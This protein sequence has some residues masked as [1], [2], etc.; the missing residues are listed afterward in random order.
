[1]DA[2]RE[3]GRDFLAALWEETRVAGL[4]ETTLQGELW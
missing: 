2:L 1:M 3:G 4:N